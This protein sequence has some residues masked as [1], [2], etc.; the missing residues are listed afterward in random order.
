MRKKV[1]LLAVCALVS[2]GAMVACQSDAPT[3]SG[4]DGYQNSDWETSGKLTDYYFV[5]DDGALSE[6]LPQPE[7]TVNYGDNVFVPSPAVVDGKGNV[8][9]VN[10]KITLREGG[11]EIVLAGGSFFANDACG[12]KVEYTI[13]L[14]TGAKKTEQAIIKVVGAENIW[15]E[16]D[17][18][19]GVQDLATVKE[20][21]LINNKQAESYRL[22]D[23]LSGDEKTKLENYAQKGSVVWK[24]IS[25]DGEQFDI[26][27][28]V[29]S[30]TENGVGTYTVYAQYTTAD[31]S[32]VAFADVVKFY[33]AATSLIE[34]G[35]IIG[36][37][38]LTAKK[39]TKLLDLEG[40]STYTLTNLLT[41]DEKQAFAQY[42]T[43]GQIVWNLIPRKGGTPI[44]LADETV[45][46]AQVEKA[47]YG[48]FAHLVKDGVKEVIYGTNVDFYDVDDDCVWTTVSEQNLACVAISSQS[49][50]D[51]TTVSMANTT[52]G[53][54][55]GNKAYYQITSTGGSQA[56]TLNLSAIHSKEYYQTF[57]GLEVFVRFDIYMEGKGANPETDTVRAGF[58]KAEGV[59]FNGEVCTY[60]R[61]IMMNQWYTVQMPLDDFLLA[62][63]E[64]GMFH[65]ESGFDVNGTISTAQ[66]T[67]LYV[68]N[69]QIGQD[70]SEMASGE[71]MI[72]L[73]GKTQ[74][75][76]ISLFDSETQSKIENMDGAQWKL[77]PVG[78]GEGISV[79]DTVDF[80]SVPKGYYTVSATR[81][82]FVVCG[83][84]VD[85][86]DSTDGFE[87]NTYFSAS[88]AL[89][90]GSAVTAEVAT[91]PFNAKGQ[92]YKLSQIG[93]A[94]ISIMPSHSDA[95]YQQYKGQ[96]V[97]L[98]LDYYLDTDSNEM[99]VVFCG[100]TGG[101]QRA[102]K[103][104][105]TETIS[106]DTLLEQWT[107]LFDPA[108]KDNWSDSM[109][110]KVSASAF[111]V[112]VGNIRF[113]VALVGAVQDA[114]TRL[115]NFNG[116]A[117]YDLQNVLSAGGVDSNLYSGTTVTWTFT[118]LLG[119]DTVSLMGNEATTATVEKK[120]Y[121]ATASVT[122]LGKV[123]P[124]Y[125]GVV[126]FYDETDGVV[127]NNGYNASDVTIKLD[128]AGV[129]K[130]VATDPA[131]KTGSY[132]QITTENAQFLA[133]IAPM[134]TKAYYQTMSGKSFYFDVY[135]DSAANVDTLMAF[136]ANKIIHVYG[137]KWTEISIAVDDVLANWD[138]IFN[139]QRT[140]DWKDAIL[141]T[142][143]ATSTTIYIGNF[144]S[145][146][147][148]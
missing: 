133:I 2:A 88:N 53:A 62:N 35:Q 6:T 75:T 18:T 124:I 34:N 50:L 92:Y 110:T 13:T 101:K 22:T 147:N 126:D 132:Y 112:Y 73:Q 140:N 120:A 115:A 138:N 54:V 26:A 15:S 134:H 24:G 122:R 87:W 21:K 66:E 38:E 29:F 142:R 141:M 143:D 81:G 80:A 68:G 17:I 52:E 77:Y 84:N 139:A 93:S 97:S 127:W 33:D 137:S 86:Y 116:N 91:D 107:V 40:A 28:G 8:L 9:E 37:E 89:I 57:V 79:S 4:D 111:D 100:Y 71:Q 51:R 42:Q 108:K 105:L 113:D 90:K 45:N 23:L 27:D 94:S 48:V 60:R 36:V 82:Q 95:Y 119:G 136:A 109:M 125:T 65:I 61:Q 103:T 102:G 69:V 130:G 11:E 106:L 85:F 49:K 64:N 67:T 144:R 44:A 121:N 99:N 19:V 131:G 72:D 20:A 63:W 46:F 123:L 47:N 10:K 96:G 16:G 74:C 5:G 3:Y 135:V 83:V 128:K 12:Y 70:T 104:W 7:I 114:Q 56:Y 59:S 58:V 43:Q 25:A 30:F 31:Y 145:T 14:A 1:L 129:T 78:G 118:P 32:F 148:A 39:Q 76:L 146:S 55:A 98:L 41:Q 117:S